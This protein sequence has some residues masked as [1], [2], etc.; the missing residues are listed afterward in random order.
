MSAAPK[1]PQPNDPLR[2]AFATHPTVWREFHFAYPVIS[3][4]ARGLSLGVNLSPHKQCNFGC[5]YCQVDRKIPAVV[6]KVDLRR[7]EDELRWLIENRDQFL[8]QPPFADVPK[9]Y[10][11]LRD[12]AFSGDGEPT[13]APEFPETARLLVELKREYALSGVK[14]VVITD[15][16]Y[17]TRPHVA[18]TL[19]LL[20]ANNGEIWTKLDAGT[21]AYFERI[22][23]PSHSLAH[24]LHEIAETAKRQPVVIQSMFLRIDGEPAPPAEIDA[25]VGRLHDLV[26]GGALIHRVQVYTVARRPAEDNVT[27][28]T[29][30]ELEAIAD[31]I[32]AL[33]IAAECFD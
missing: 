30:H 8:T 11:I 19:S 31:R 15:A 6:D 26:A 32:R 24:V 14:I 9:D 12:F 21:Q 20:A 5:V 13:A 25:Y 28:M 1:K 27:P 33:G 4:R 16:C 23:A 18:D 29:L 2:V 10:H 22:N 3:R 17:L 7:L